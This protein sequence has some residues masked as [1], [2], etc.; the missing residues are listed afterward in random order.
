[1]RKKQKEYM[2]PA[3]EDF[4]TVLICAVRYSIGR[5]TY[6]PHLVA[7]YIEP[8]LPHM[9][10][11]SLK[12]M[13]RDIGTADSYGDPQIDEPKWRRLQNAIYKELDNR[14]LVKESNV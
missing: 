9:D 12:V 10:T 11:R 13:L 2:V 4:C 3:D 1:M 6:M 8:M 5:C 7:G 14:D